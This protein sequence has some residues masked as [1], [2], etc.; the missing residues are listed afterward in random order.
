M[1]CHDSCSYVIDQ[2]IYILYTVT[3]CCSRAVGPLDG[4]HC[5]QERYDIDIDYMGLWNE[6]PWGLAPRPRPL[7][8]HRFQKRRDP[9]VACLRW[10]LVRLWS[11]KGHQGG[12][13]R[14]PAGAFGPGLSIH[15]NHRS[16]PKLRCFKARNGR[17]N[18]LAP[19]VVSFFLVVFR[20]EKN[21]KKSLEPSVSKD[22]ASGG[23]SP[24]FLNLFRRDERFQE[25]VAAVG[26]HYPC[27]GPQTNR[28]IPQD[29]EIQRATPWVWLIR[30]NIRVVGQMTPSDSHVVF[31]E[32]TL[33][34]SC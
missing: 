12:P 32:A 29:T 25:L 4:M 26:L 33:T 2:Y 17:E 8:F 16:A 24:D 13:V 31:A 28:Q 30:L 18:H 21:E 14:Y 10:C 1:I 22:Q 27:R 6:M 11:G 5:W 20:I 3:H 7:G 9:Q 19:A 23:I 34:H 15:Q